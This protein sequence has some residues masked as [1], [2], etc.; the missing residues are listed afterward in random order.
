MKCTVFLNNLKATA[1]MRIF[2]GLCHGSCL[3]DRNIIEQYGPTIFHLRI[4][5]RLFTC[6][7]DHA[8]I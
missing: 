3:M 5:H 6:L 2:Q 4:C 1:N 7:G 8:S